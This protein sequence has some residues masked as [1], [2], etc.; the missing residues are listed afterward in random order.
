[1]RAFYQLETEGLGKVLEVGCG[2]GTSVVRDAEWYWNSSLP[3]SSKFS[4]NIFVNFVI[5]LE[6]TKML[7]TK[8]FERVSRGG[9]YSTL[10]EKWAGQH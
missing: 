9:L 4:H 7:F 8:Y 1:M 2:K 5:N 3:Y 10:A 6:I